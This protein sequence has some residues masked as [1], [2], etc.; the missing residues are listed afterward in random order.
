MAELPIATFLRERLTE[1]DP[2]FELRNGTGFDALFFKPL[3]FIVQPLRDEAN[4]LF[5]AQSFRRI[6]LQDDPDAFDEDAVDSLGANLFVDRVE[7]GVSSGVVR[8]FYND[9]VTREYPSGGA[10]FTGSNGLTYSN[11]APFFISEATMSGQL[12]NGLYYFDIPV[13]SDASG[14]DTELG[15]G[16]IVSLAGDDDVVTVTNSLA[17]EGGIDRETNSEYIQRVKDSIG[18]RDLV[19]GKG[20]NAILFENFAGILQEIQPI[21]FGDKEMMRDVLFNTHI[22]GKVDGYVKTPSVTT[23]SKDFI[24]LLVDFTRQSLTSGNIQLTGTAWT[25][26]NNPNVDRTIGAPVVKEIKVSTA[27][28]YLSPVDFSSPVDLS[29]NQHVKVGIDGTFLNIRVAGVN[30]ATTNRNEIVAIINNAFG[31]DV[32]FPVGDSFILR[33]PTT[34]LTSEVVID[35]PDIGNS[36]LTEVFDLAPGGAP[37]TFSGD[38]PVTFLEGIHYEVDDSPG[39]IRRIVGPTIVGPVSTGETT[40]GSDLFSDATLNIFISVEAGDIITLTSGSEPADYRVLEKLSN[41]QLRLDHEF[42]ATEST[43]DYSITRTGIK[44]GELVF[45]SYYFNPL[46]IDIQKFGIIDE[47]TSERGIRPGRE[48]QTITD[49]AF[50]RVTSIELIDPLTLEPTGTV[51]D[52]LGGWGQGGW[53]E[54]PWGIGEGTDYRLIVVKPTERFSMFEE[55][56]IKINTGFEGLSFRVNYEY[57]PQIEQLHDFVRSESERV[58][59]GDIL[60]KSFL[61][62]YVS[63]TIRYSVDETDTSIPDNDTLQ[64]EVR[65]FI[66]EL[67]GGEDVEFSDVYQYIQSRVDPFRRYNSYIEPFQLTATIHNTDGTKTK[68]SGQDRLVIPTLDPFPKFTS[69]PLSPTIARWFAENDLVLERVSSDEL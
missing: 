54:G 16:E 15:A 53:G 59:D 38:G 7:G 31:V 27:A 6:L 39:N 68:I 60:M 55:S 17:I 28:E 13:A 64:S 1:Y 14:G 44:S 25:S 3:Q 63:G 65:E 18:V 48:N 62:S 8:V 5:I 40:L 50:L 43:L 47:V 51:L 23:G 32:A 33:S 20:F 11:P 66:D 41:N 21:G 12:E 58:L 67:R 52:G 45:V 69:R 26:L 56:Y 46:S 34:G 61:P 22:G 42:A 49:L 24:G 35:N 30:P 37:H 10:V 4:D 2:D 57:V 19:T 36:A 9:P 29:T